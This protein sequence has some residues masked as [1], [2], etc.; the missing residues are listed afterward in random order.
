MFRAGEVYISYQWYL[1]LSLRAGSQVK[2]SRRSLLKYSIATAALASGGAWLVSSASI[3]FKPMPRLTLKP[4][5]QQVFWYLIPAFLEGAVASDDVA[6]KQQVLANIDQAFSILEPHTQA[7]LN[8]LLEILASRGGWLLLSA[9]AAQLS[10]LSIAQRLLL[11][12]QWQ[13]HYLQLLRQAYQGLHELIT[14]A[15]YGDPT[16]W[17]ELAYHLP[18]QARGLVND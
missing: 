6:R 11:L 10:E 2:L 7:E 5:Y 3:D 18:A 8:Q 16:A 15:W 14:A 13:Q 9:G 4:Q 12:Q 17:P 1:N